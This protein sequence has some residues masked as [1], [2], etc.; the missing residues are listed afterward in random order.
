MESSLSSGNYLPE[1]ACAEV[2]IFVRGNACEE[3]IFDFIG[4]S[5]EKASKNPGKLVAASEWVERICKPSAERQNIR[6]YCEASI[7][8]GSLAASVEKER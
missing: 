6:L 3:M 8:P 4:E 7:V 5:T 1:L 2:A